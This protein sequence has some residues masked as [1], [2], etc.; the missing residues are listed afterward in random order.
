M[1]LIKGFT[2]TNVWKAFTLN[3]LAN[4]L[5]VTA[6]FLVKDTLDRFHSK[7]T[8]KKLEGQ[9]E[10]GKA[11]KDKCDIVCPTFDISLIRK[12]ITWQGVV[13]IFLISFAT[14]FSAYSVL[15]FVFGF[16][17]GQLAN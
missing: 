8:Q 10:S 6:A 11:T 15:H 4:A 9:L 3:S 17:S 5:M 13:Y 1:P 14:C 2:S 7:D 16:G 12:R